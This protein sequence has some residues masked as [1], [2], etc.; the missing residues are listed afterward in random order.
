MAIIGAVRA[1]L[2]DQD[3]PLF[4]WEEACS[5]TIYLQNMGPHKKD[6]NRT[7]EEA[8]TGRR[9]DIGNFRM[10][11]CLTFCHDPSEKWAKLEPTGENGIFVGYNET[12]KAYQIYVPSLQRV[13]LR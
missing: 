4:L 8:F 6:G 7:P 3:L 2:H 11:G 1:M 13:V 12:L 9:L 10:V 5:T